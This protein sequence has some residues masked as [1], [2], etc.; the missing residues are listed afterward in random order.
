MEKQTRINVWVPKRAGG[1][2]ITIGHDLLARAGD[3]LRAT[4]A[5]TGGR[6]LVVS[7][8]KVFGLYGRAVMEGLKRASFN[9]SY[10]LMGDGEKYKSWRTLESAVAAFGAAG[11]ERTDAVI[12]LGGGVVG[13]L[14]GMAAA[15]YLRGIPLIQLPTTLLAQIDSSVGGKTGINIPTG[16]NLVGVFHHPAAVII[17]VGT[18]NTLPR[19]E[20]TAGWCEAI[21]QGAVADRRL[22]LR[23]LALLK[24]GAANGKADPADLEQLIAAQCAVKAKIVAGDEREDPSRTDGRSRRILN[25]GHTFGHAL[26]A[27]TNYRRFRHGEAVGLGML[28]AGEIAKKL[29]ILPADEL[30]L[31]RSAINLAG[32]LPPTRDL[33]PALI[34]DLVK[35]DKKSVD[36]R[37]KWVLLERVGCAR[38]IDGGEI[39][40]AIL[41]A[42]LKSVLGS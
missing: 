41:R 19:R 34:L 26:E 20:L 25:F 12:A 5:P 21:K 3:L 9:A 23:T 17:D 2:P 37:V 36:G 33:N 18:L 10:W 30:E 6:V 28:A 13:D 8:A 35:R 39:S 7:N 32:R 24:N 27:A 31:L 22:F 4:L 14:A 16:K 38:I 29:G 40:S 1:Y 11:L 42:S 15:V